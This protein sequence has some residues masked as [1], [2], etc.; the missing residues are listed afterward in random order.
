MALDLNNRLL[1]DIKTAMNENHYEMD[2]YLDLQEVKTT[3]LGNPNITG[4]Y[5][6]HEKLKQQIEEDKEGRFIPIPGTSSRE[7]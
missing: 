7:G 1:D 4:M 5:E 3:F 2:W 6:E